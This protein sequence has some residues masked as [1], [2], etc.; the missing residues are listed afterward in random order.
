MA[1]LERVLRMSGISYRK[2]GVS[3][4]EFHRFSR[5]HAVACAKIHEKHGILKYQMAYSSSSLQALGHSMRTPYQVNKHDLEIEYY[6]KDVATLLAISNDEE[7]K[8]L[9]VEAE[10]YFDQD[11]SKVTLTWIETYV[12]NGKIVNINSEGESLYASVASLAKVEESEKPVGKYY[13]K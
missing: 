8:N 11:R 1:K 9:H 13:G 4:E 10:P 2:E 6:F 3:E 7:F 12:E 5:S